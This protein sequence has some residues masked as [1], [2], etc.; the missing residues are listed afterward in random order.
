MQNRKQLSLGQTQCFS[1]H[2]FFALTGKKNL[3]DKKENEHL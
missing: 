1:C 3:E 2:E